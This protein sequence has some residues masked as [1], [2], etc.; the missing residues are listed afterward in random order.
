MP[1]ARA[2]LVFLTDVRQILDAAC[3]RRL[4]A[5]MADPAV[6]IASGNLKIL[7]G[8][9][10]EEESTGLYWRYENSIR[11]NLSRVDSMLGATGPVYLLRRRLFVPI[12]PDCLLDDMFLPL[13]VHLAGYRLVLEENAI[14]VDEPTVFLRNSAVKC[15]P[16][17]AI[18][19]CSACCR[20]SSAAGIACASI[21]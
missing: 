17:P 8:E 4:V 15:A 18:C 2:E 13:S 5:C 20:G 1:N 14:A 7:R 11:R 12:P 3:L 10:V 16:R 21:T 19:N 6:G 9:T